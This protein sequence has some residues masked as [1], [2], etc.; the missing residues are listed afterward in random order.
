MKVKYS[1][2]DEFRKLGIRN[3]VAAEMTGLS[4]PQSH[5]SL[6]LLKLA[7]VQEC[8]AMSDDEIGSNTIL[9]SYRALVRKC[10]RSLK[11]FPPAAENLIAQ[12]RRTQKLPSINAAVDAY[13]IVV[14]RRFLALGVHD[15]NK[16]GSSISFRTSPGN[17]SFRAVGGKETKFTQK[18]DLVYADENRVLAWLDSKDSDEVKI[19]VETKELT[20]IIQG[21]DATS[22][23]YN[24]AALEEAC[25]LIQQFSGGRY[26]MTEIE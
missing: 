26:E 25:R 12:V 14:I 17:E 21:T 6:D 3:G 16:L 9:E 24:R 19:D 20:I 22:R 18:G 4:I 7:A 11:K 8:I 15:L 23:E 10:G 13:N 5:P 1:L 2:S